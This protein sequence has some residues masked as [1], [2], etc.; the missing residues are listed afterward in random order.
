MHQNPET[1]DGDSGA[2]TGPSFRGQI[3]SRA[4]KG[5]SSGL[6]IFFRRLPAGL[7]AAVA[8]MPVFHPFTAAGTARDFHPV[9]P[10][11][12][13]G[14][15]GTVWALRF[16]SPLFH[17]R[18]SSSGQAAVF[19]LPHPPWLVNETAAI[20]QEKAS[21]YHPQNG[22]QSVGVWDWKREPE[23][24]S[25]RIHDK[26]CRK[27]ICKTGI[28]PAKCG[29]SRAPYRFGSLSLKISPRN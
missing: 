7:S 3:R 17:F 27:E 9:F 26:N 15:P 6:R 24:E 22:G 12:P 4:P 20:R 28:L 2:C 19:I 18:K 23:K 1:P 5:R 25:V 10:I 14:L 8:I 29:A 11:L 21:G 16:S 13:A